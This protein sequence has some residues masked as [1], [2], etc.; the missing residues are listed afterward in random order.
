MLTMSVKDFFNVNNINILRQSF[1][2]FKHDLSY[3]F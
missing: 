2:S 3:N 1:I